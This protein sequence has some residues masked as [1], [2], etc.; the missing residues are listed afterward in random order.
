VALFAHS[1]RERPEDLLEP[2]ATGA[3]ETEASSAPDP[4]PTAVGAAAAAR[5][6]DSVDDTRELLRRI[7]DLRGR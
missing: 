1:P 6:T 2:V 7:A 5:V 3:N 4:V